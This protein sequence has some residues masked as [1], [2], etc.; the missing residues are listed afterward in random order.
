ML[1]FRS[2]PGAGGRAEFQKKKC[3]MMIKKLENEAYKFDFMS[4]VTVEY[5]RQYEEIPEKQ[6]DDT[7]MPHRVTGAIGEEQ[8]RKKDEDDYEYIIWN[9]VA[10]IYVADGKFSDAL[11]FLD[12]AV[13][14]LVFT[15]GKYEK[16]GRAN[17]EAKRNQFIGELH[18]VRFNQALVLEKLGDFG[19]SI[20][21]VEQYLLDPS[22]PYCARPGTEAQER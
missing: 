20:S 6:P 7:F 19:G 16:S 13:K 11:D 12:Y 4:Y 15:I 18:E 9:N 14:I 2:V 1:S 8:K 17:D 10:N 22:Q 5:A 3:E 21:A